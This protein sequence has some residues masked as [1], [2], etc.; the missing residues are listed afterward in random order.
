M[1]CYMKNI[2]KKTKI[3]ILSA[4]LS[5]IAIF[6]IFTA[7]FILGYQGGLKAY[8][9]GLNR[10][11]TLIQYSSQ[12]SSYYYTGIWNGQTVYLKLVPNVTVESLPDATLVGTL[13]DFYT[14]QPSYL[15]PPYAELNGEN[16][17]VWTAPSEFPGEY[18]VHNGDEGSQPIYGTW[19][20]VGSE[21]AI[22][23]PPTQPPLPYPQSSYYPPPVVSPPPPAN[24][25]VSTPYFIVS[26]GEGVGVYYMPSIAG[27]VFS[28][29]GLYF[30]WI[31]NAWEYSNY[32]Y[33][34]WLPLTPVIVL[35]PPLLYGPPPP[36]FA[37]KPYFLWWRR[38][39]GPWYRV[40]HPAWWHR[41]RFY[42]RHYRIWQR[43]VLPFYI[44]HP[45]YH[46]NMRRII[47][48]AGGRFIFPKGVH[49]VIGRGGRE[50][51]PPH[52]RP[53]PFR[54]PHAPVRFRPVRHFRPVKP[55][56][57]ARY[58][59][60]APPPYPV[61]GVHPPVRP[62][63]PIRPPVVKPPSGPVYTTGPIMKHPKGVY[64][65]IGIPL[66][67]PVNKKPPVYRYAPS[68]PVRRLPVQAPPKQKFRH[69][70]QPQPRFAA[71]PNNFYHPA[72]RPNM[73]RP[74]SPARTAPKRHSPIIHRRK[75]NNFAFPSIKGRPAPHPRPQGPQ[76]RRKKKKIK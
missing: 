18:V 40:Y 39:I 31:N 59:H 29:N 17:N 23:T 74:P 57:P 32:S 28:Y 15:S 42:I 76:R 51:Y 44:R 33:G 10:G 73:F 35:P 58:P 7:I 71:P 1:V 20:I 52:I 50:I 21:A 68:K 48:P 75:R 25:T 64:R 66:H 14:N 13:S 69:V 27:F 5:F 38:R 54:R 60:P 36:V 61:R 46:G 8:A 49:P 56:M 19:I 63:R 6:F 67:K 26:I 24:V 65:G 55:V 11:I 70:R 72:G 34:P 3:S 45:F 9:E 62:F 53:V 41:H 16:M 47:R 22:P 43:R 30:S 2:S 37:Y 12:T 4:P